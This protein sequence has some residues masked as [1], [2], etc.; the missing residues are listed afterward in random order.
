MYIYIIWI[1]FRKKN[2]CLNYLIFMTISFI[3]RIYIYIYIQDISF[4]GPIQIYTDIFAE[5]SK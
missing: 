2:E 4:S 1:L 5:F 3:I